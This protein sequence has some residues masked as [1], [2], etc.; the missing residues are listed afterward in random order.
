MVKQMEDTNRGYEWGKV[1][2]RVGE[3]IEEI[4]C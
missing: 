3:E 4:G 1:E 2:V